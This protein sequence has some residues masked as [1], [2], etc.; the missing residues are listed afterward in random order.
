MPEPV[1]MPSRSPS[2]SEDIAAAMGFSSFGAKPNPPKKK[3]KLA[4]PNS[5]GSGSNNTPL[6]MRTRTPGGQQLRKEVA[7]RDQGQLAEIRAQGRGQQRSGHSEA[8]EA[9]SDGLANPDPLAAAAVDETAGMLLETGLLPQ[10]LDWNEGFAEGGPR[11]DRNRNWEGK[12]RVAG[13][14]PDPL[15]AAALDETAG[16]LLE[17]GLLPQYL[18][19]NEGFAEGGPCDDRNR[20]GQGQVAGQVGGGGGGEDEMRRQ[21]KRGDGTWDWQAL[22]KGV[23]VNERGDVAFY[24]GSFVED[25]WRSLG[26]GS[27]EGR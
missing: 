17:M 23:V 11:D 16:V 9:P 3:R 5:E 10:Y 18:D 27:G 6:G 21:G 4:D 25:P 14:N 12:G 19:W 8:E 7:S 2:P 24:D 26:A 1:P 22:R 15:A 13:Q 20:K